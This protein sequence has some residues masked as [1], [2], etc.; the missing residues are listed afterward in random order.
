MKADRESPGT[1]IRQILVNYLVGRIYRGY[2][3]IE[4]RFLPIKSLDG[5]KF[6]EY[7]EDILLSNILNDG[8]LYVASWQIHWRYFLELIERFVKLTMLKDV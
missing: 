1:L 2:S 8:L 6:W 5:L 7:I 3:L 4:V